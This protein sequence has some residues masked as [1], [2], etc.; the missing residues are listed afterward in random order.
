M[1]KAFLAFLVF[2]L[3][4]LFGTFHRLYAE[5]VILVHSNDTHGIFKP[6][7]IKA[8]NGERLVGGMEAA[9][10]Y[11]NEIR[12]REKNV[13][14]ID[15]GDIM[16]GTLAAEVEYKGAIGGAMIEFLNRLGYDLWCYGNHSFD[17]GQ[18]NAEKLV[19]L[20]KFPTVMANVVYKKKG[21]LFHAKPYHIFEIGGLEIGVIAVM[22]EDFLQEVQREMVDGLDVLPIVPSLNSYVPYLDKQTDLIIVLS[23]SRF[24]QGKKIAKHISGIDIVL[25]ASED[26]RFEEVDGVLVKST[27]GHQKTLGYLKADV[28]DDKVAS[29][30]E[31]LIWLWADVDL[32]PS[33]Q[34]AAFVKEVEKSIGKEYAKVIGEAKLD[35]SRS[36]Y[37]VRNAPIECS[38]GDWITDVMRWK[39]GAQIG[40]H[41]SGGIRADIRAGPIRKSDVF[42]VYPFQGTLVV[43]KL[44]GQQLKEVFESDVERGEDR[45]QVS[46]L[47]YKHYLRDDKPYGKR[48]LYIEVNGEV[49]V[50]EGKVLRPKKVY[51][52]V[53]ND[54]LVGHA[55]DKYFG[56][57]ATEPRNTGMPLNQ[58]L[59]DWLE[60]FKVLDYRLEERIIQV[61]K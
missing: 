23:H 51:T 49:L 28:K 54:Y 47:K 8:K 17:R 33:P 7:K 46:G 13:L 20:A 21:K 19:A 56:F 30:E 11:I 36:H 50:R 45:L 60:R 10:H 48:V 2:G 40:L 32:K 55:E 26:G 31:K 22:E 12:A 5:E 52:I 58:A 4:L 15:T 39:T 27:L 44:T 18:K 1:K 9:S 35:Q 34:V 61:R 57:Q 38:L 42:D 24:N 53:S 14:L 43:F 59:I 16:T 29:Y 6:F 25:V 41:N 37:P 3:T